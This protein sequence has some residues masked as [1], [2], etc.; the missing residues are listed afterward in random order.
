MVLHVKTP[1]ARRML[2]RATLS[3]S[4]LQRFKAICL[5][6]PALALPGCSTLFG[7]GD[8][9]GAPKVISGFIGGAAVDEPRAALAARDVLA[10]GGN[11]ADAAVAAALMLSVTLPSRA[12]L[13]AS[14]ACLAYVP[15]QASPQAVIFTPTAGATGGDRQAA[16]P[17][18]LRGLFLLNTQY[19]SQSFASLAAPAEIAA[20][21]GVPASRA[22]VRDLND[23]AAPLLA[24]PAAAA[25]FA[26]QGRLVVEGDTVTQPDLG[27]LLGQIR[28][29]GVGDFYRGVAAGNLIAAVR[30]AGGGSISIDTLRTA[31]PQIVA[32]ITLQQGDVS[33]AFLPPPADGGLA[34]AAADLVL[35]KSPDAYSDAQARALAS[36]AA[37]RA[38]GGDPA[39]LMTNPPAASPLSALPASTSFVVLDNK[40]GAVACALTM[41][42]LFGTGRV[43]PGTGIVLAASPAIKPNPLLA[44]AIAW[45]PHLGAFRAAVSGSGQ[46][47]APVAVAAA[48]NAALS[49]NKNP[50]IPPPGRANVANCDG[51]LPGDRKS[52]HLSLEPSS[53]G[54][55]TN[56]GVE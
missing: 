28:R 3:R 1:K 22:L 51:Y 37:W 40:G 45:N 20:R 10:R 4:A 43:A 55:A 33:I 49:G 41:N 56:S 39:T 2:T 50:T 31:L 27:N 14:G 44:A 48:I 29:T 53:D 11:A 18:L 54:L 5:L 34:A 42:N 15:G 38:G 13:G 32:P 30:A 25:I 7:S 52:C 16:V 26:P 35:Q 9:S 24:D 46:Q 12:S 6:A 19:G 21:E 36:A 8:N 23:V 47:A 17:M